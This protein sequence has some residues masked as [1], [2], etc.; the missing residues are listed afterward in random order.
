MGKRDGIW[1]FSA[2]FKSRIS[3]KLMTKTRLESLFVLLKM[4]KERKKKKE[5]KK[6]EH[7]REFPHFQKKKP[8]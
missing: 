1:L 4:K 6:K 7:N 5:E 3:A 8:K 2:K